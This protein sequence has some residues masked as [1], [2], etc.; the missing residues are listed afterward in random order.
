MPHVN[1]YLG[2]REYKQ[3][4][5]LLFNRFSSY[6]K[7]IFHVNQWYFSENFVFYSPS[8]KELACIN[9]NTSK[10]QSLFFFIFLSKLFP[11][12]FCSLSSNKLFF[13]LLT[14]QFSS[15]P[16]SNSLFL[17]ICLLVCKKYST[18]DSERRS[19]GEIV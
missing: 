15:L 19:R 6:L 1:F 8:K 13:L 9:A 3:C 17:I 16:T 4:S 7:F 10:Q 5:F 11:F 14:S 2:T 12:I 18:V